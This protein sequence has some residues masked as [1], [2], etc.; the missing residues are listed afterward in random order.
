M[1]STIEI[2]ARG[3]KREAML[4]EQLAK[5]EAK[6]KRLKEELERIEER[7]KAK[8]SGLNRKERNHIMILL[9]IFTDSMLDKSTGK[10]TI[11]EFLQK[12][13][14]SKTIEMKK[15]IQEC[16]GNEKAINKFKKEFR[17]IDTLGNYLDDKE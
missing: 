13:L 10:Q 6:A 15:K 17:D 16:Q 5:Q 8:E 11:K 4:R 3:S 2:P 9:G 7:K 1:T 14:S 12:T